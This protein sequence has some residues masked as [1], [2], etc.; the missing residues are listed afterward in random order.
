MYPPSFVVVIAS[1]ICMLYSA[2]LYA[3]SP[4]RRSEP[5]HG[6]LPSRKW[7]LPS[8]QQGRMAL[9]T[10]NLTVPVG[11]ASLLRCNRV[12]CCVI[13]HLSYLYMSAAWRTDLCEQWDLVGLVFAG[14]SFDRR[15][16]YAAFL[17]SIASE[18][19]AS[20]V[21]RSRR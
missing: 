20:A 1:M 5:P 21:P 19:T 18:D 15:V 14:G 17:W 2:T 16:R 8:C 3:S 12:H 7:P 11:I 6:R 4:Q 13:R 9:C 10:N